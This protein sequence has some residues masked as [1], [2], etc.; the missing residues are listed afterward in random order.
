ML[1]AEVKNV[2]I[3]PNQSRSVAEK[4]AIQSKLVRLR[5][6]TAALGL[7]LALNTYATEQNRTSAFCRRRAFAKREEPADS[8]GDM[9]CRSGF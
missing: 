3:K 7:H 5:S 9:C 6:S 2:D 4:Y 1:G 8:R